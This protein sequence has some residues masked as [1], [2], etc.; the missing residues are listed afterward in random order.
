VS[1]PQAGFFSGL[2]GLRIVDVVADVAYR[3][4]PV[5]RCRLPADDTENL[6]YDK[7]TILLQ[8]P[9]G[10]Q[11]LR[12]FCRVAGVR[13]CARDAWTLIQTVAELGQAFSQDRLDLG[14]ATASRGM[15]IGRNLG[16]SVHA[17]CVLRFSRRDT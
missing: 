14:V 15:A 3:A 2:L 4:E 6:S 16:E 9:L 8:Y 10:A 7:L 11:T 12:S 5:V 13:H 17:F 1:I